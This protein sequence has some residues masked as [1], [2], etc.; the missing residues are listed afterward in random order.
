M[1]EVAH[2]VPSAPGYPGTQVVHIFYGYGMEQGERG[3]KQKARHTDNNYKRFCLLI[4]H[5]SKMAAT[6]SFVIF[7]NDF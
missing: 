3:G 2:A 4:D 7:K 1:R 5:C 6:K